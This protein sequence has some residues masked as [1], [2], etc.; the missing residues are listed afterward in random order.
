MIINEFLWDQRGGNYSEFFGKL[1]K[2]KGAGLVRE[3]TDVQDWPLHYRD[4]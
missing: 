2:I 4:A 3:I 1:V